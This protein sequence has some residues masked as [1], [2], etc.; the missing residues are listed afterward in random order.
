MLQVSYEDDTPIAHAVEEAKT[1]AAR[2]RG[3]LGRSTIDPE[4]G[5]LFRDCTSIHMFGMKTALDVVFLDDQDRVVKIFRALKPW[6]M[7]FGGGKA[8]HCLELAPGALPPDR[9]AI[10]ERLSICER[11]STNDSEAESQP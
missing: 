9:P 5:M 3:L 11:L 10:G 7:A 1:F 6:Q 4:E 8:T 2:S